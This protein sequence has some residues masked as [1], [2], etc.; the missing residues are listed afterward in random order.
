M[1]NKN[2]GLQ[3]TKQKQWPY[4]LILYASFVWVVLYPTANTLTGTFI[5]DYGNIFDISS[6]NFSYILFSFLLN[7]LLYFVEFEL[8]FWIYRFILSFKIYSFIVPADKLKTDSRLYF[9]VR[10][11]FYGLYVNLCFFHPYLYNYV[12]LMD[13]VITLVVVIFY[14]R[15][16]CKTYSEPI[17][18]HFVFK[19]FCYP[20]FIFEGLSILFSVMGVM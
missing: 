13:I 4:L 12:G 19:Y 11:F 8:I 7:G 6:G 20:I 3:M 18:S 9:I 10:N 2:N 14:V 17:V 15:H 16:L 1:A 5:F